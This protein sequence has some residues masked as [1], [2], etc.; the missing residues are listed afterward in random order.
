[1]A[2]CTVCQNL[3]RSWTTFSSTLLLPCVRRL[4]NA[5]ARYQPDLRPSLG[6]W[7]AWLINCLLE[8]GSITSRLCRHCCW[9]NCCH[10]SSS[11]TLSPWR[12]PMVSC[13][14]LGSPPST[15]CWSKCGSRSSGCLNHLDKPAFTAILL[16]LDSTRLCVGCKLF[17]TTCCK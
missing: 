10:S 17:W 9:N 11:S 3:V 4:G 8:T 12:L 5:S 16:I 14:R 6:N 1:M 2:N 13:L 7:C 15:R